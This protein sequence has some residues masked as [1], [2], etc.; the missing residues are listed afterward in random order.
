[1]N[2][3]LFGGTF[4]PVHLGHMAVARA[5]AQRYALQRIYFVPAYIPPHK[6]A[7]PVTAFG[8]RFAMLA[9]ATADEAGFV[10]SLLESPEHRPQHGANYT[11][12]TVRNFKN[13]VGKSDRAFFLIGIDAFLEI[14]S[15]R[16]PEALLREIEFVV[17][18]RPGFSLADVGKA[19][20]ESL[21]PSEAVTDALRKQPPAGDIVLRGVT[22]HLLEGVE[23]KVSATQIRGAAEKG[24]GLEKLVGPA[25]A[26]YIR[27]TEIYRRTPTRSQRAAKRPTTQFEVFAGGKSRHAQ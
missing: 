2:L 20:P 9:V 16:E 1:M 24:R 14:A 4:D 13:S 17:A 12:D 18:S 5:A 3:A 19:L 8:H 10:P 23:E 11:I 26:N 21:R 7:I 22:I 25:V 27:K 15:W 6:Q